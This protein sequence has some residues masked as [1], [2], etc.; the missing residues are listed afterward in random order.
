MRHVQAHGVRTQ[1]TQA[2]DGPDVLLIHGASSD[3]GL[4][5]PTV[6]P[7]LGSRYRLTAY[8]RPG[9]GGTVERPRGASA[10]AF[11]ARVAAGVIAST[12]LK[13]PIVVAH[14]Y[15]GAIALRL[16][17]DHA[18]KISGLVLIAPVAYEWP[19]GVS[20]HL[21]W[22]ANPLIGGLF[23][24]VLSRPVALSAAK[25]GTRSA[26]APSTM[27]S[28]YFEG[29]G[30]ARAIR[31]AAMRANA[32][33]LIPLKAEVVAQQDRYPE[34]AMPIAMLAGDGD[35]VVS[36]S[37]HSLRLAQTLPNARIEVVRGAGHLPHEHAPDSLAKLLD[38]VASAR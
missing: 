13:R 25:Q 4:W 2:G 35:S 15:G 11:Q 3:T 5:T 27:P 31:P 38:W 10:L 8:D 22:S 14:S 30:V 17:L 20:W 18:D 1:V 34:L 19:G 7:L 24:N 32:L 9:M 12:D 21:Y 29:A 36:T 16:A 26:F 23:N 33:D 37:I 28:G 6:F